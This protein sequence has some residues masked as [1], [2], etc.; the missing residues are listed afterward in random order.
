MGD[1]PFHPVLLK[2]RWLEAERLVGLRLDLGGT[3]LAASFRWPGQY[4]RVK[5]PSGEVGFFALAS[6]PGATEFELLIKTGGEAA[7]AIAA[8]APGDTLEISPAEGPGF[9]VLDHLGKDVLLFAVGSG[10]SPIRSLIWYLAA[11]REDYA[12]VTLF[13]GARTPAHFAYADELAA[14]QAEG[15]HVLRVASQAAD[16]PGFL[17]GYVQDAVRQHPV[18][19]ANTVVFV[20]GMKGMVEGVA[21][22]LAAL[23]VPGERIFQNF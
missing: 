14:W 7:D 12:G 9:P 10:I 11:R 17:R 20:C 8:L 2:E 3:D 21:T 1:A 15:V 13:F 23:G 6:R 5:A 4:V 22:E 19:P 16:E 18:D